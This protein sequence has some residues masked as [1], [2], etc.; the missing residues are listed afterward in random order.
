MSTGPAPRCA[1]GSAAAACCFRTAGGS[2]PGSRARPLPAGAGSSRGAWVR[3]SGRR[4]LR[5]WRCLSFP[6]GCACLLAALARSA[7]I[8]S[9]TRSDETPESTAEQRGEDCLLHVQ[10][11]L[12][13]VVADRLRSI[14]HLSRRLVAADQRHAVHEPRPR[15]GELEV[16]PRHAPAVARS[17]AQLAVPVGGAG[18]AFPALR[19]D[20]VGA[21][22]GRVEIVA[23]V[24]AGARPRRRVTAERRV[25]LV[26]LEAGGKG[27]RQVEP[28]QGGGG[29][30]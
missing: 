19:I 14:D 22:T 2:P 9:E 13:L 17:L 6:A 4:R 7:Y 26:R 29:E 27:D 28:E 8:G 12:G 18:Q 16:P 1:A 3:A 11:V 25:L 20:H 24:D 10:P 30:G 21:G 23:K 15:V 5:S